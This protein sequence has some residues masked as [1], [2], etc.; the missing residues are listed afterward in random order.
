LHY[1]KI[2]F[3]VLHIFYYRDIGRLWILKPS[4][5]DLLDFYS[6]HLA[7]ELLN[8][9]VKINLKT[10][11]DSYKAWREGIHDDLSLSAVALACWAAEKG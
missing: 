7:N 9:K 11:H 2:G 5:R 8:F 4:E 6:I 3:P 10:A 1:G